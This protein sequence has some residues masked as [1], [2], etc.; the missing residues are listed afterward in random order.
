MIDPTRYVLGVRYTRGGREWPRLDCWGLVRLIFRECFGIELDPH[1]TAAWGT[2]VVGREIVAERAA[3]IPVERAAVR[4]GDIALMRR[5]GR[6]F[7][8][9]VALDGRSLIHADDRV[10]VCV[11]PLASQLGRVEFYRHPQLEGPGRT[12]A[13]Q[14]S[15]ANA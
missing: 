1:D 4:A 8:V 11:E 2:N 9:G 12:P 13:P 15:G 10:N 3:W 7:H 6:P 14:T 5:I